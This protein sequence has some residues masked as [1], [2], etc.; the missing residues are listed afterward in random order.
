MPRYMI[1]MDEPTDC[2][3]CPCFSEDYS[4]GSCRLEVDDLG[5]RGR[6]VVETSPYTWPRPMWCQ[7]VR[8]D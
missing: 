3:Q 6:Y 1:E 4:G 7:L 2:G 8:L 5:I